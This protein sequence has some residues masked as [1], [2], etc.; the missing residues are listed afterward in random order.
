MARRRASATEE[1]RP[2]RV[3]LAL[4]R[5]DVE[6]LIDRHYEQGRV[7]RETGENVDESTHD[8]W[9][10]ELERWH[11]LTAA[12]LESAYT[13]SA[14]RDEFLDAAQGFIFRRVNQPLF[15]TIRHRNEATEGGLNTLKSLRERLEY[16]P[17]PSA[18]TTRPEEVQP[19]KSRKVFLVHG[20]DEGLREQVARV[21]DRLAFK[22]IILT[23]HPNQGKTLI[24]KFE[25]KALDVGFAVVLL[26]PDDW[27]RGPEEADFPPE[28]TR[29]RLNVILEL[30]Y[31]MGRLSRAHIA[32]LY[33][34]GTELPSDIHGLAYLE[35]DAAGAWRYKLAEEL[36]A[37]G[38]DVDF[39]RLT[40]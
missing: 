20:R 29:P 8:E 14:P 34:P 18:E 23:E 32:A 10:R 11:A 12:A 30:G 5:A 33:R 19:T 6:S 25:A 35:I 22:P 21:L 28:P 24:E 40:A 31:F 9:K 17:G 3:R 4:P 27:G 15:E 13:T 7:L 1:S 38:Y 37:A 36:R 16:T 39:N 26:T 2:E